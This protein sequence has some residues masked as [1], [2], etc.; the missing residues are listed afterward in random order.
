VELGVNRSADADPMW[1]PPL[2]RRA[3]DGLQLAGDV[4]AAVNQGEDSYEQANGGY[5]Q[6]QNAVPQRRG[7]L[8]A[9]SSRAL[10]A[11]GAALRGNVRDGQHNES[12]A[13]T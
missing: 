10:V 6:E 11:H 4:A 3:A 7:A 5:E 13:G 1:H 9:G 12:R 8:R 2:Q